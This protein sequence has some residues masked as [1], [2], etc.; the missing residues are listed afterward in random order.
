MNLARQELPGM[1]IGE[2][3]VPEGRLICETVRI[4]SSLRDS[5]AL[6]PF[7]RQFLPG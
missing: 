1:K 3:R 6:P 7:A 4:H 5:I 2:C